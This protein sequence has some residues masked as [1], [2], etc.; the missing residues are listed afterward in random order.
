MNES[1]LK[2]NFLTSMR[3]STSTVCVISA[4]SD[5]LRHAMTA[6]SVTS[7]SVDPPSMLVCINKEASIHSSIAVGSS[8]LDTNPIAI[9]NGINDIII[10]NTKLP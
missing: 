5:T 1:D 3:S 10:G 2:K 8:P 9:P 7:L 4:K 6:I